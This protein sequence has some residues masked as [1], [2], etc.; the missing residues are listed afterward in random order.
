MQNF[1][2]VEFTRFKSF[3]SFRLDLRHFNIIVGPNNSG[4]STVLAAF[5][6]LSAAM[7][8]A[9]S[10]QAAVIKG[11]SGPTHGHDVDL[12]SISVAEE[13]IFY[14][15]DTDEPAQVTF[16]LSNKNSLTLWFPEPTFCYL[17]MDA[18]G[19]AAHTPKTFRRQ[20]DCRSDLCKS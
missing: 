18:Q 11:P 5:R 8:K 12:R 7:R 14:N 2:R 9:N 6:I 15:Y 4:K 16:H 3:K 1:T 17:L 10:R 20:F 19:N 13:N